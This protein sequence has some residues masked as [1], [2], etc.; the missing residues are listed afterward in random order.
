MPPIVIC[1][2]PALHAAVDSSSLWPLLHGCKSTPEAPL[3]AQSFFA[4]T[5]LM[6]SVYVHPQTAA[7]GT[8][9]DALC[10][11]PPAHAHETLVQV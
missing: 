11:Y 7:D 9:A 3:P 1:T 2:R 5:S 4:S 6:A 8:D 10:R